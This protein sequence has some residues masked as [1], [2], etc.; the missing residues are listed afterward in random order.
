MD[1]TARQPVGT[2]SE[3]FIADTIGNVTTF[4]AERGAHPVSIDRRNGPAVLPRFGA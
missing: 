2:S 1:V 4:V 3:P